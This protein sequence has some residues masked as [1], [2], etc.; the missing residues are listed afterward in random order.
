MKHF[1]FL[2]ALMAVSPC[3]QAQVANEAS[4]DEII[5]HGQSL[6]DHEIQLTAKTKKCAARSIRGYL[7]A[8]SGLAIA[9]IDISRGDS[10][11]SGEDG[12]LTYVGLGIGVYGSYH[13]I[14]GW[15]C[16]IGNTAERVSARSIKRKYFKEY[17]LTVNEDGQVVLVSN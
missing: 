8:A 1:V 11:T 17:G 2:C 14:T 10:F 7:T 16:T 3:L 6:H 13:F 12:P 9:L 15:A 5:V 4:Q